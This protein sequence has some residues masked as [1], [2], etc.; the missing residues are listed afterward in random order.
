[1]ADFEERITRDTAPAIRLEH[2][3]RY[4]SARSLVME[5]QVWCDLGCGDGVAATAAVDGRY[6][7]RAILV[8]VVDGAVREA[9]RQIEA[10][11]VSAIRADLASEQGL[12]LVRAAL[13]T[14]VPDQ[15]CITCFE[16]IE[17]LT[18][19]VPLVELLVEAAATGRYTVVLSVPNDAFLSMQNPYHQST[20]GEAAFEELRRLLPD[21]TVQALQ[22]EVHGSTLVRTDVEGGPQRT[23]G[24]GLPEAVVA[25]HFV[26]AFGARS[27]L[28]EEPVQ[29]QVTDREA[30]RMWERQR[31]SDLAFY[32]A[33]AK[34]LEAQIAAKPAE[35]EQGA[36]TAPP[37][38]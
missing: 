12:S 30:E 13:L 9:E 10:E 5:S 23:A 1:M 35:A 8:D 19:F 20:W 15:G 29:V 16:L 3:V 36:G 24:F 32:R 38:P 34:D 7:G 14:D 26:A 31:D 22:L 27:A 11:N 25:S 2:D 33:V 4:L 37:A 28:L 21:E 17:H 18:T 6:A